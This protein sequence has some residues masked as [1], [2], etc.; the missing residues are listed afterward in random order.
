MIVTVH[1]ARFAAER[2]RDL[3][4]AQSMAELK[5]MCLRLRVGE[6]LISASSLPP[7]VMAY[8]LGMAQALLGEL[9]ALVLA[10]LDEQER[11][12]RGKEP[13]DG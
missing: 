13:S 8:A 5:E 10:A 6:P 4:A 3:A 7:E 12:T 11:G 2:A 1:G 9:S